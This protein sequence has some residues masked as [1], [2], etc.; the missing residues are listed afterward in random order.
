MSSPTLPLI[1][2]TPLGMPSSPRLFCNL[3]WGWGHWPCFLPAVVC[4]HS[5]MSVFKWHK[6][7]RDYCAKG[8][9]TGKGS[10][11]LYKQVVVP[12]QVSQ[13]SVTQDPSWKQ[14]RCFKSESFS[15]VLSN[16]YHLQSHLAMCVEVN[17]P[18][19]RIHLNQRKRMLH[20]KTFGI[21]LYKQISAFPRDGKKSKNEILG[22]TLSQCTSSNDLSG[23]SILLVLPTTFLGLCIN[24][25]PWEFIMKYLCYL[26]GH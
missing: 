14:L 23:F 10:L 12:Y 13:N 4:H 7:M 15:S 26:K 5:R 8:L 1:S 18:N 19:P 21:Q 6:D 25:L 20:L 17:W 9:V 24:A 3:L 22:S 16:F 2:H 11:F